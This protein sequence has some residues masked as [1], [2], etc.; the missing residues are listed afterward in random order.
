[1]SPVPASA[2][3]SRRGLLLLLVLLWIIWGTNW[4]LI[5]FALREMSVWGFRTVSC[6][7][8]G[9]ALLVLARWRGLSLV[10][11]RAQWPTVAVATF[12]YLV[13]WNVASAFAAVLIP[14]GQAA[15]LGFTMPLWAALIG[16]AVL[17]QRLATR[18]WAALALGGA[19]VALLAWRG[20]PAYAQA[21]LGVALAL[22]GAIGWAVGTLILKR[23]TV[24]VPALVLTGWQLL[25]TGLAIGAVA[26][27]LGLWRHDGPPTLPPAGA[28]LVI[29]W[30]TLVPMAV[31]NW[32]WFV[33][34]GRLPAHV[35]GLSSIMV[36]VVAMVTGALVH[37]EPLGPVQLSAMACCGAALWL[38][39]QV[40]PAA[41][42]PGSGQG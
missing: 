30:M 10:I 3:T 16:W 20:M 28:L 35:A 39:L 1:M 38:A 27:A 37:G 14:S 15:V 26:L 33:I 4:A 9:L 7:G 31:G 5:P 36:P 12:F 25:A 2:S 40:P 24:S 13:L 23:S 17:G 32:V 29:A 34:V 8:A 42:G 18:T 6:A 41:A 19:A 22:M 11:P 21:P